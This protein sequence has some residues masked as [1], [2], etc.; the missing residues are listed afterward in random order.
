MF[1]LVGLAT[2]EVVWWPI[3][4]QRIIPKKRSGTVCGIFND[5]LELFD[6]R[7]L[8]QLEIEYLSLEDKCQF[9][10]HLWKEPVTFKGT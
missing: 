10:P 7:S 8:N 1:P 6:R 2:G 5:I 9:S 3:L 4:N